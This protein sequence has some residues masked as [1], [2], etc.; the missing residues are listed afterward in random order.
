MI[1][2]WCLFCLEWNFWLFEMVIK[3]MLEVKS[4][5]FPSNALGFVGFGLNLGLVEIF[6]VTQ[7][8]KFQWIWTQPRETLGNVSSR[9]M[10]RTRTW[11]A[12]KLCKDLV[13]FFVY[14]VYRWDWYLKFL[15][16]RK[17]NYVRLDV[18]QSAM[19]CKGYLKITF[20]ATYEF[21]AL[22]IHNL[23]GNVVP[24]VSS[25]SGLVRSFMWWCM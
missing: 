23:V 4:F 20:G 7:R 5:I 19:R 13:N 21:Q 6:K 15:K 1:K 22:K 24:K 18:K 14:D 11:K 17:E 2:F 9:K 3:F 25:Q 16:L 8:C 12:M 10:T